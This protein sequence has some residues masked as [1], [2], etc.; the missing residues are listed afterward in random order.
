MGL[1]IN[2][3]QIYVLGNNGDCT[4]AETVTVINAGETIKQNTKHD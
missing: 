2:H 1:K 4:Q 3:K